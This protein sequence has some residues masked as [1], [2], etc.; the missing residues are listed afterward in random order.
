MSAASL[1]ATSNVSTSLQVGF[2]ASPKVRIASSKV[3]FA[4]TFS[5][6]GFAAAS[7]EVNSSEAGFATFLKIKS[8]YYVNCK[9]YI[10]FNI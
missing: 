6:V 2:A 7:S 5:E 10:R 9:L 8:G 1:V 3:G 4:A